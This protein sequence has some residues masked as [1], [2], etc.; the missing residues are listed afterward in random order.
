MEGRNLETTLLDHDS[1]T[2]LYARNPRSLPTKIVSIC[3]LRRPN[4]KGAN[5]SQNGLI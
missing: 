2:S 5:D 4:D 1:S 3:R